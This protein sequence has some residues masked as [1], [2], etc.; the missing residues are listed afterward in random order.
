MLWGRECR[1]VYVG[2][3]REQSAT[4]H[5][6]PPA[7]NL[8]DPATFTICEKL[9]AQYSTVTS[10]PTCSV[11]PRIG[12]CHPVNIR[13]HHLLSLFSLKAFTCE[14]HRVE[15]CINLDTAVRVHTAEP[16]FCVIAVA[17]L[18]NTAVNSCTC[19]FSDAFIL[20]CFGSY[21]ICLL[22]KF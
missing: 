22:D 14:L 12:C 17:V 3:V 4:Q 16:V 6:L 15:G 7:A 21:H 1:E 18:I 8:P 13:H 10:Q 9:Q 11:S 19:K 2:R 20:M 5:S